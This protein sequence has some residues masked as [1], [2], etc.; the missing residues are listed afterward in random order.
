MCYFCDEKFSFNHRCP[1][2]QFLLLQIKDDNKDPISTTVS[3]GVQEDEIVEPEDHHLSFSALKGGRRVGTIRFIA[4]IEKLS[5]TVLIVGDSFDNFLQ[6]RVAKFL[7]LPVE[8]ATQV[9][10]MVDN[11]YYMSIEG[12]VKQLK[13]QAQ[14]NTFQ[15]PIFLLLISGAD[16]NLG[17]IVG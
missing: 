6:P 3:Q 12:L 7:K 15:L 4:Y 9:T 16:L 14:G 8:P 2:R 11:G 5:V 13:I 1:N 17:A 10:V